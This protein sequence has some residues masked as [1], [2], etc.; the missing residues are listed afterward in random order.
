LATFAAQEPSG[1]LNT[2]YVEERRGK[3]F[4]EMQRGH[5]LYCLGHWLQAGIAW[6]RAAGDCKLLDGLAGGIRFVEYLIEE[7]GPG[8]FNTGFRKD[9]LGGGAV[10][11]H[12]GVIVEPES[13]ALY[14]PAAA[15]RRAKPATLGF[16]PYYAFANR[17]PTP[18]QVWI[19]LVQ[20]TSTSQ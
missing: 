1:Y 20:T 10:L 16:I 6:R 17:E 19:P 12:P 13:D 2:Y 4:T 3:R 18:M 14:Q 11:K 15:K 8:A 7:S 9:L 5:E